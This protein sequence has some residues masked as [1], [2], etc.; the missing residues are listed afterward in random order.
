M[1]YFKMETNVIGFLVKS[2]IQ[3]MYGSANRMLKEAHF[4]SVQSR[5]NLILEFLLKCIIR[6]S[7]ASTDLTRKPITF[8]S[9]LK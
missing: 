5:I 6:D 2:V 7:H 9:I 8:V 3:I 4:V 1:Y